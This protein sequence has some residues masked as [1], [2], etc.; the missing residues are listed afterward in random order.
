MLEKEIT[1]LNE[2]EL[3]DDYPVY[4][5]YLYVCDGK[6]VRSDVEG[7]VM[8]LKMDLRRYYKLEANVIMNCDINGRTK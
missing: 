2:K 8:T 7:T 3:S 5:D 6:V 1:N 4:A